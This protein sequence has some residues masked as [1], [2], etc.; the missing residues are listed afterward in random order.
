MNIGTAIFLAAVLGIVAWQVDKRGA[1]K[2]LARFAMWSVLG[3]VVLVGGFLLFAYYT[4]EWKPEHDRAQESERAIQTLATV[5]VSEYFGI[6][7]GMEPNAVKY[8]LGEPTSKDEINQPPSF[9]EYKEEYGEEF[10]VAYFTE[11]VVSQL[12]CGGSSDLDC[13][14][15]LGIS[16][17]DTEA[18]VV[19]RVGKALKKPSLLDDGRKMY[20]AGPAQGRVLIGLAKERVVLL[21]I[22]KNEE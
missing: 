6:R 5:G 19:E 21:G 3:L 13:P 18:E 1:W 10:K 22:M 14:D 4:D 7:L 11:G 2:K 15:L 20:V 9:F 17:G 16:L 12:Q 8:V